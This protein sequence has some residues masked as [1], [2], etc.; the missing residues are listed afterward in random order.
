MI[1]KEFKIIKDEYSFILIN[2]SKRNR[3]NIEL[4]DKLYKNNIIWKQV[5]T[6]VKSYKMALLMKYNLI[7]RI[8]PINI[9]ERILKSYLRISDNEEY[10]LIISK[11][12]K[13]VR[14]KA[15]SELNYMRKIELSDIYYQ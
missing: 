2:I 7:N 12:L 8:I 5:H 4:N 15:K 13:E 1:D 10:K 14:H 11:L 9:N 3:L 6:H